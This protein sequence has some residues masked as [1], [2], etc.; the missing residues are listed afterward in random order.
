MR[1]SKSASVPRRPFTRLKIRSIVSGSSFLPQD[2]R[3]FGVDHYLLD[4]FP[5]LQ[6]L[7]NQSANPGEGF[8]GS[9][10]EDTHRHPNRDSVAIERL[11]SPLASW[12]AELLG[13]LSNLFRREAVCKKR[14]DGLGVEKFRVSRFML[15]A[16]AL[17]QAPGTARGLRPGQ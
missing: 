2:A 10:L 15:E 3:L 8:A 14:G 6:S 5:L 9:H 12:R 11:A 7:A 1:A 4:A 13:S 16:V 17:R